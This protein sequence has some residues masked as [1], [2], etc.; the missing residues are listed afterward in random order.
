MITY[1]IVLTIIGVVGGV[2]GMHYARA[3][4]ETKRKHRDKEEPHTPRLHEQEEEK[5][6]HVAP[7]PWRVN[8]V[9]VQPVCN[10][11]LFGPSQTVLD[12]DGRH[13]LQR[14]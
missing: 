5:I 1:L 7:P 6:S 2:A 3:E 12:R 4:R 13:E 9:L 10:G 8:Q 11:F 14:F